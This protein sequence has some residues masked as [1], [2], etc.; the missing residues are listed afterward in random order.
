LFIFSNS[1][2][3]SNFHIQLKGDN[4]GKP[5]KEA[6]PNSIG[7]CVTNHRLDPKYF[8]YVVQYLHVSGFFKPFIKGSVVPFINQSD[9]KKVIHNYF[10]NKV[11]ICGAVKIVNPKSKR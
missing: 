3:N 10:I 5:L 7:L 9:I 4:A 11:Q 1:E 2:L 8:F 6:I